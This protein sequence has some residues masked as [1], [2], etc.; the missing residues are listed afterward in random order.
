MGVSGQVAAQT[1]DGVM[2]ISIK[3]QMSEPPQ[4]VALE[5]LSVAPMHGSPM[6]TQV[7]PC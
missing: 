5:Q 2:P 1:E 6:S 4:L 7:A 3:Q